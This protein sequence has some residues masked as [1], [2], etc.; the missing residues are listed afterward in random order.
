MQTVGVVKKKKWRCN[1]ASST[2]F[3]R[4][5]WN[6]YLHFPFSGGQQNN[7]RGE[8]IKKRKY[9][10]TDGRSFL[11]SYA[12]GTRLKLHPLVFSAVAWAA[13]WRIHPTQPQT[14]PWRRDTSASSQTGTQWRTRFTS[15]PPITKKNK[16]CFWD[17]KYPQQA[18]G[19]RISDRKYTQ[20]L[21]KV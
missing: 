5:S 15:L 13:P 16:L 19:Q 12:P 21:G 8:T 11:F 9:I 4:H 3:S 1:L 10:S 18:S 2:Y 14:P 6:I 7:C 20:H 17:K